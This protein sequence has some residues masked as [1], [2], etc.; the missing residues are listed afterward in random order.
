MFIIRRKTC[1]ILGEIWSAFFLFLSNLPRL[2]CMN[3]KQQERKKSSNFESLSCMWLNPPTAKVQ[4]Y[5][6]K[7]T[8]WMRRIN[9]QNKNLIWTVLVPDTISF[10][11]LSSKLTYS[12]SFIL[13]YFSRKLCCDNDSA[14]FG[15]KSARPLSFLDVFESESINYVFIHRLI[16]F[17]WTIEA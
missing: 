13:C 6:W 2:F 7:A 11:F 1:E 14:S 4:F 10:N 15:K 5:P 12:T 9:N 16:F 3:K 17:S 8:Q